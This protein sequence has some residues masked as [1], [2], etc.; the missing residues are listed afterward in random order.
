MNGFEKMGFE[1][2]GC[3]LE[4]LRKDVKKV[5]VEKQ[6]LP[7]KSESF[8]YVFAGSILEHLRY[9]NN[10]LKEAWRVLKMEGIFII[11]IPD[12][13]RRYKTF[14]D[15]PTHVQ[16]YTEARVR[17]LLEKWN[18]EVIDIKDFRNIP[19]LWRWFDWAFDIKLFDGVKSYL[20]IV[21]KKEVI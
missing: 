12:W 18:F 14:W 15:D 10:L 3:D 16:P 20:I 21:A 9:P 8:E 7:Y 2:H 1:V 17:T 11:C 4:V 5:D 6:K 13:K 19:Y